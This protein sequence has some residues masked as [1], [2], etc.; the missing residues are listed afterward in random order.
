MRTVH[1]LKCSSEDVK[2]IEDIVQGCC[3]Y[4]TGEVWHCNQCGEDMVI[5]TVFSDEE[6]EVDCPHEDGKSCGGCH[7]KD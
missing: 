7:A 1:C 4:K 5:Q 3:E 6:K 2:F